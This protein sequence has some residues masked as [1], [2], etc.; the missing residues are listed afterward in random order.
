M[1]EKSSMGDLRCS[2]RFEFYTEVHDVLVVVPCELL[3]LSWRNVASAAGEENHVH[4]CRP[5]DFLIGE[6][7]PFFSLVAVSVSVCRA[8][9]SNRV[10]Q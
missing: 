2:I 1:L 10:F 4:Q 6:V 3:T 5:C 7:H 9:A 8:V